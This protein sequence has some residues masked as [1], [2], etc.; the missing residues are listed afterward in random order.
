MVSLLILYRKQRLLPMGF[1]VVTHRIRESDGSSRILGLAK[2]LVS[3]RVYAL[4]KD[5]PLEIRIN[6]ERIGG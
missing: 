6:G 2:L 1:F 5:V 3:G 4:R